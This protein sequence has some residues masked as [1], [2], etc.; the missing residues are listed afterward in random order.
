MSEQIAKERIVPV[1]AEPTMT[2][3]GGGKTPTTAPSYSP[4]VLS[5]LQKIYESLSRVDPK[6]DFVKE[7][8]SEGAEIEINDGNPIKSFPALL[9]YMASPASTATRPLKDED[10]SAPIADYFISSSHNTYLTGNQ[11]YSNASTELYTNVLRRGC[12]CL[13]I[14]VW[15]GQE[16]PQSSAELHGEG[17]S[18]SSEY[19]HG[20]SKT[21]S[22]EHKQL[23][24]TRKHDDAVPNDGTG[25]IE[26]HGHLRSI[27]DHL[28]RLVRHQSLSKSHAVSGEA[29]S[30]VQ[31]SPTTNEP[32]A[33]YGEPRVLH[34]HT[35]TKEISFR[36]VCYAIRHS[37]FVT[38]DLPVI[39]SLEVHTSLKQQERMVEI[40]N[41]AWK[42]LL[43]DVTPD[44]EGV[45]CALPNLGSLKR[46]ILI[47]TKWSSPSLKDGEHT[48]P[49]GRSIPSATDAVANR[50][51][52]LVAEPPEKEKSS[53]VLHAL[54]RLAVYAR[55]CHFHHFS[56]PEAIIPTHVF[57]LSETD[58]KDMHENQKEALL[59]HNKSFMMRVFP[60]AMRVTSSNMDPSLF[61]KQG[62][63]MVALNWQNFD[64]GMMLNEAMFAGRHG[65]VLK[66]QR[67]RGM[68]VDSSAKD[69]DRGGTAVNIS[70]AIFAGQGLA[71]PLGDYSPKDFHPYVTCQLHLSQDEDIVPKNQKRGSEAKRYKLRTKASTGIDP[72]FGGEEL[73][74]PHATAIIEELSFLRL[75]VKND[76]FGPDRLAAW[77]C[78]RL[79]RLQQGYRFIR[80]FNAKGENTDGFLLVKIS[81]K[82]A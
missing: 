44:L 35:L 14:D 25:D 67:Y 38:N 80:L 3:P 39:V 20:I 63:Q 59:N 6:H 32:E 5:H 1:L 53:K 64:M 12:R 7:I 56:Q 41:E 61:W 29:G 36:D 75:K 40:I 48:H 65:W 2:A 62:V 71:L 28:G 31:A 68:Q 17:D 49:G 33:I 34:G 70:I 27:S 58:I 47:K 60:S 81:K 78:I 73:T 16:K 45:H 23:W 72:D 57:S 69:I 18:G 19:E 43:V 50:E 13:E 82:I 54:S 74:F 79:D 4:I 37:A 22:Q 76:E 51:T 66:P 11:L 55:G 21:T 10:L 30:A 46:K 52:T 9:D 15:D 24:S 77:S 26:R 42:D 8:Q